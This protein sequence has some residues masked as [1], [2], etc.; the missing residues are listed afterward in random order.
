MLLAIDTSAAAS[1]ALLA[2]D[3][4]TVAAW[5]EPAARRHAELLTP[6]LEELLGGHREK[7]RRIVA[8]IGPGPFTG[9][10]V[11]IAAAIG[12]GLALDVPV[13]GVHSADALA[14]A[15]LARAGDAEALVT[16]ATDARRKEVYWSR[17]RGMDA[18]GAPLR[19]EG[20]EVSAPAAMA[21]TLMPGE[22]RA[23]RGFALYPDVLGAPGFPEESLLD[24]RAEDLGAVAVLRLA[25][26]QDL[27][28]PRP[29]YLRRPDAAEQP[30]RTRR[31]R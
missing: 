28:P 27:L 25:A 5:H 3:G 19:I 21:A 9:L 20:P 16:V 30:A 18:A 29:E 14:H 31:L 12:L 17:Y 13:G 10:R 23:G 4:T 6:A 26:G 7:I 22:V 8:G 1:A 24:P 15:A 11:G 2:D